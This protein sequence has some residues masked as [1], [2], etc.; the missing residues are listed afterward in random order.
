VAQRRQTLPA[1]GIG[2][3]VEG[4]E[5]SEAEIEQ[6][7]R[8]E[9][10]ADVLVLAAAKLRSGDGGDEGTTTDVLNEILHDYP[11]HIRRDWTDVAVV[12]K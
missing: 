8:E 6:M 7:S 1:N 2:N 5:L 12:T 11:A 3:V 9:L 10:L 4:T